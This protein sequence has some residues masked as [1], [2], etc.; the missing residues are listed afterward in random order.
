MRPSLERV[1]LAI[2]ESC[3][4]LRMVR[5]ARSAWKNG[6]P[7]SAYAAQA[8]ALLPGGVARLTLGHAE[9]SP[10][11][12]SDAPLRLSGLLEVELPDSAA[13]A[14]GGKAAAATPLSPGAL[15][16]E[17]MAV[18]HVAPGTDAALQPS[19]HH[20][21]N[22]TAGPGS[23]TADGVATEGAAV[24][25]VVSAT[26]APIW[27][28]APP[29]QLQFPLASLV[30][31]SPEARASAE[32]ACQR[33]LSAAHS[34]P[35]SGPVLAEDPSAQGEAA[36]TALLALAAVRARGAEGMSHQALSSC[37]LSRALP[38]TEALARPTDAAGERPHGAQAAAGAG[39][40]P[41]AKTPATD[42]VAAATT[43]LPPSPAA[44]ATAA[45]AL[46]ALLHHGLVRRVPGFNHVSYLASEHSQRYLLLPPYLPAHSLP[47]PPG[48][49]ARVAPAGA[50]STPNKGP[51]T[52][53][54]S[55]SGDVAPTEQGPAG[56]PQQAPQAPGDTVNGEAGASAATTSA[57][58]KAPLSATTP[59]PLQSA[60]QTNAVQQRDGSRPSGTIA[61]R[62]APREQVVR[63]WLDH[64]GGI[65]V[66]LWRDLTAKA[67]TLVLRH[68]GM[69][70][71]A[72]LIS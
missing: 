55:A 27:L 66:P 23:V 20:D 17:Q 43:P 44:T 45:A 13:Q 65:N 37:L 40:T 47:Q 57:Q 69:G 41:R 33:S 22:A 42:T 29:S 6:R 53:A 19:P 48:P 39:P 68:P 52:G 7:D 24:P 9:V 5:G 2:Q 15:R 11:A 62:A 56:V 16:E 32:A 51:A 31:T 63:P 30:G 59:Q 49:S 50:S 25:E 61:P 10:A 60:G 38:A 72:P 35:Q 18:S 28:P 58:P 54:A 46:R 1:F 34:E 3:R 67:V 36:D 71:P 70:Q 12:Q 14:N 8:T 4:L 21:T 26:A 64:A